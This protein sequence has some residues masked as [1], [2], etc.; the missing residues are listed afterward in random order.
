MLKQFIVGAASL[1][2]AGIVQAAPA[3]GDAQPKIAVAN[4]AYE[5]KV[6]EYFRVVA[7]SSK[8]NVNVNKA[9]ANASSSDQYFE[10]E[11]TTVRIDRGELR[12]F[13]GD[14][15]GEL[16]K[17]GTC[18]LVQAHGYTQTKNNETLFDV[19]ARIKRG[20]FNG[21]DYV[22]FG[23]VSSIDAHDQAN[24]VPGASVIS[25]Q[26][27]MELVADFSLIDTRTY[28]VKAGFSAM[29][30]GADVK[31]IGQQG[32]LV[33]FNMGKVVSEVSKSLG[34]NVVAQLAEQFPQLGNGQTGAAQA[35]AMAQPAVSNK[36]EEVIVLT[37]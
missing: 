13:T 5:E 15:K 6:E 3:S 36:P 18:Q 25:Y 4:L 29:G 14:I 33:S 26:R 19:I 9:S 23:S 2:L 21:A 17:L 32:A 37:P 10:A 22:L 34:S 7:A 24:P 30:E 35:A 8:S 11:G 20:D 12:K 16:L 28:A 31:L 1:W 27:N